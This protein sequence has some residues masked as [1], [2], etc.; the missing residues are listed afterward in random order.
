MF[1]CGGRFCRASMLALCLV[2]GAIAA[3]AL[4]QDDAQE[5]AQGEAL[6]ACLTSVTT[7]FLR[8]KAA[9]G[10]VPER[11]LAV[12]TLVALRRLEEQYCAH[13]AECV[14]P[15]FYDD[16]DLTHLFASCLKAEADET[17]SLLRPH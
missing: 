12:D 17:Y 5:E 7:D 10:L 4:A 8:Q 13:Y 6:R 16:E 11:L 2:M 9:S 15:F 3:P 14:R 1:V